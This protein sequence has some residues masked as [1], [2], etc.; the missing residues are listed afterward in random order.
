MTTL[1]SFIIYLTCRY[2]YKHAMKPSTPEYL[3]ATK[4]RAD[5]DGLRAIAVLSVVGF[6]AFPDS[7]KGGFI[8]VDIFFVISGFLIST[9]IF[10]NLAHN[11]FS[12]FEFYIKRIRRIFPSLLMVLIATFVLGWHILLPDEYKR[13]GK[14]IAA[15]AGFVSNFVLLHESGYFDN[16]AETKP[17]LHLW[18]LAVEEQFYIAWPLL[19]WVA[20]KRKFNL[21]TV[22][23]VVAVISFV[24]NIKGFNADSI[25]TFYSPQTRFWEL[26]TGSILAYTTL[27]QS[28]IFSTRKISYFN[29]FTDIVMVRNI[30]SLLGAIFVI[31]GILIITKELNFSG[32]LALLPTLGAA[33]IISAGPQSWLNRVIL[34]H[35]FL[36]WIGL[37]SFPL[38]LW[39]WPLLTFARIVKNEI[40]T[41]EI[42]I[43]CI[44]ISILLSWLT[45][46]LIEK[47]ARFGKYGKIKAFVLIVLMFVVGCAGY[48]T[49]KFDDVIFNKN[50]YINN[51]GAFEWPD[52]KINNQL[53]IDETNINDSYCLISTNHNITTAL[54]GD[55]HANAIFDFISMKALENG[56]GIIMMGRAGCPPFLGVERNNYGC[57]QLMETILNYIKTNKNIKNVIITGRFAATLSGINFGNETTPDFYSLT[58]IQ[59]PLIKDRD[60]IFQIGL[61][62]MIIAIHQAG[63][64]LSIILDIPELNF[65]PKS[66]LINRGNFP[67]TIKKEVVL[68]RQEGYTEI[69]KK[70]KNKYNFTVI[71]LKEAFCNDEICIGK[72]KNNILYRDPNHLGINGNVF[73]V[74]SRID[75][76]IIF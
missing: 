57:P 41:L 35:P 18:T 13:L 58:L 25:A 68:K 73:L 2:E 45:Y 44:F 30:Q 43:T 24:L 61:E 72:Y 8:G 67:C 51:R 63:K 3:P 19:L 31:A 9:I 29:I 69:I 55:S 15:G 48:N 5:I 14:H 38:Y 4:Y 66:C 70:L 74:N 39:H 46:E 62:N 32:T 27:Y 12:F 60:K 52:S 49:N 42:R 40:P 26:M 16:A 33:L 56:N 21:L 37:I 65:D 22:A 54:I 64:K 1:K 71:D 23:I 75:L 76:Q 7:I 47:P 50:R 28:N 36:V 17:L 11:S 59:D 53:C 34:S 10:E 20:W 6:H